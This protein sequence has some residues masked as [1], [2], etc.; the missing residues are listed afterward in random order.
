[1]SQLGVFI[2]P[3]A[4]R[5]TTQQLGPSLRLDAMMLF[6]LR[7]QQLRNKCLSAPTPIDQL[8]RSADFCLTYDVPFAIRLLTL[9]RRWPARRVPHLD[10][11][12]HA[13]RKV[14]EQG[15]LCAVDPKSVCQMVLAPLD[16]ALHNLPAAT[17]L[18]TDQ[19]AAERRG[20]SPGWLGVCEPEVGD[21]HGDEVDARDGGTA[22]P[23]GV[24]EFFAPVKRHRDGSSVT[25][26]GQASP[27]QTCAAL[28][29][30]RCRALVY[31]FD[32]SPQL[33]VYMSK[34][35]TATYFYEDFVPL[36]LPERLTDV[37]R[38]RP[39]IPSFSAVKAV[40]EPVPRVELI[41]SHS[42][43]MPCGVLS[44]FLPS[45]NQAEVLVYGVLHHI[46]CLA[47]KPKPP[48]SYDGASEK[49]AEKKASGWPLLSFAFTPR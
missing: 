17:W 24:G 48:S 7:P 39:G 31:I 16:G 22:A 19:E 33:R 10:A 2:N 8:G 30:G 49:K 3:A 37:L 18:K 41:R 15:R 40:T 9:H 45:P 38:P 5:M 27:A 47:R 28:R 14:G 13:A 32:P 35:L 6:I 25:E 36:L 46:V 11:V 12:V 1:M 43:T 34:T 20:I 44:N 29:D 42:T 4:T 21:E 23:V 26:T